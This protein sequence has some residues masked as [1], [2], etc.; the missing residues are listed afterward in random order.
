MH[1]KNIIKDTKNFPMFKLFRSNLVEYLPDGLI[2]PVSLKSHRATQRFV[3]P[4]EASVGPT[5]YNFVPENWGPEKTSI[6]F[7]K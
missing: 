7:F 1:T 4:W 6:L 2:K 5:H 3:D